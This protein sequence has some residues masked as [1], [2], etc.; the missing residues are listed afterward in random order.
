ML[1]FSTIFRQGSD[2]VLGTRHSLNRNLENSEMS[3]Y[4]FILGAGRIGS[5]AFH[6]C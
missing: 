5:K 1:F 2:A 3:Y 4:I 6:F